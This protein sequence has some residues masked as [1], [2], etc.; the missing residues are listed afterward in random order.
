MAENREDAS[1][2]KTINGNQVPNLGLGKVSES[3]RSSAHFAGQDG[4]KVQPIST[5]QQAIE[6]QLGE[7]T[8][9]GT[10]E[11]ASFSLKQD[12][13]TADRIKRTP[14]HEANN[15]STLQTEPRHK[16]HESVS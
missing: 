16:T 10:P 7:Q 12:E 15:I 6:L 4:T 11:N 14:Q 2:K 13:V 3:L 5:H 9:L 1:K 8:L